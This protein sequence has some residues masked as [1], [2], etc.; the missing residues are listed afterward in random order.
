MIYR[1]DIS[2]IV[3]CPEEKSCAFKMPERPPIRIFP[4]QNMLGATHP[5]L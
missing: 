2:V 4:N 5:P 3:R 1:P